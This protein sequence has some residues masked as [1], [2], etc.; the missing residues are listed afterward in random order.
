MRRSTVPR[1]KI[2]FLLGLF[3]FLIGLPTSAR[4]EAAISQLRSAYP[5]LADPNGLIDYLRA[6]CRQPLPPDPKP[7]FDFGTL[8]NKIPIIESE[9]G[10]NK[11]TFL[12]PPDTENDYSLQ[13]KKPKLK[14]KK[15]KAARGPRKNKGQEKKFPRKK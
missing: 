15:K 12:P 6:K 3:L 7:I 5:P 10:M 8:P 11:V 1:I 9:E 13:S 4:D 14:V 2:L